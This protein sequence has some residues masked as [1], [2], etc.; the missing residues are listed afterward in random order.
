MA[1][2][3]LENREAFEAHLNPILDVAYRVAYQL[4]RNK[5][6]AMDLLQ[7]ASI[8]AFRGFQTFQTGSNFKAWFLRVL[9]NRYLKLKAKKRIETTQLDDITDVYLFKKSSENGLLGNPDDPARLVLD[10]LDV[11]T[12][13]NA[14]DKLPEEFRL[15]C[16][17]YF[18]ND[19][20]YEQIA[21]VLEIPVGT[22]RSRLHRGRKALQRVLWDLALERGIVSGVSN[23]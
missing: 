2:S 21:D 20:G 7:D 1:T 9:T 11:E 16:V 17:M 3:T 15:V 18:M 14:I 13:Q 22:V 6:D 19:F 8:Q 12:V 5:E 23:E 10:G 4:T